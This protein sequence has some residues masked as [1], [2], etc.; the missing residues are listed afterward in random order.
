MWPVSETASYWPEVHPDAL[1]RSFHFRPGGRGRKLRR[2]KDHGERMRR[3]VSS[4][5]VAGVW[6]GVVRAT[7]TRAIGTGDTRIEKQEWH[8]TQSGGTITGYYIAA[9]TF[10][11]GDGRPYVCSRQPQFSAVQRFDVSGAVR[12]RGGVEIEEIAQQSDQGR[13]DPGN[14]PAPHYEGS[15]RVTC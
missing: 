3:S 13:C 10:V 6:D 12:G 7:I 9:L 5:E 11:S 15:S 4:A 14:A 1:G 8:L 2:A